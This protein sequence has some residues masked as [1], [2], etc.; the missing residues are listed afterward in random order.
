VSERRSSGRRR[1]IALPAVLFMIT[2][3]TILGAAAITITGTERR[4]SGNSGLETQAYAIA[5]T[6]LERFLLDRER[7]GFTSDPPAQSESTRVVVR[8]GYADVVLTRIRAEVGLTR[9]GIYVVRS[10][11]V[12]TDRSSQRHPLAERTIAQYARWQQ[13]GMQVL[14]AWT[15][16]R[17]IYNTGPV[18]ELNGIDA[19]GAMPAVAGVAVPSVPG[20]VQQ[21]GALIPSGTPNVLDLGD[22][23]ATSNA[24]TIDW[25]SVVDGGV[26]GTTV[27]LPRDVWPSPSQWSDPG[28]WPIVYVRGNFALPSDG[29]GLL[30]V[31]GN[32]TINGTRWWD[33][34]VL[35]GG[36]VVANGS[37]TIN[38]ATVTGLNAKSGA[39]STPADTAHGPLTMRFHSC[40]IARALA[41]FRGLSPYRNTTIDNWPTY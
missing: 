32:L 27:E 41:P 18:G 21:V 14:A 29:R 22:L 11:G 13:P 16:M 24:I 9:P 39:G 40:N 15:S 26:S 8:D 28:F 17:G 10:R 36:N 7:M 3:L 20:Y 12:R 30:I 5:R 2:L 34:I 37:S 1:G 23:L 25:G 33:G 19:C 35:V 4:V 31:T 38:G 6:G